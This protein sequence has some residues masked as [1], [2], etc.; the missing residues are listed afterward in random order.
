M[1]LVKFVPALVATLVLAACSSTSAEE[2]A[3]AAKA[4]EAQALEQAAARANDQA[5]NMAKSIDG[6]AAVTVEKLATESKSASYRCMNGKTLV[7]TYA[8][9]NN[10]AR[11]VNVRLGKGKNALVASLIRDDNDKDFTAFQSDKYTWKVDVGLTPKNI[12]TINGGNFSAKGANSD[13]ILAK[14]C[15]VNS[16]A[17]NRLNK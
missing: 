16:S 9:E 5:A 3:A 6:K 2:A 15:S 8:F 10:V 1:K 12:A 13:E 4:K 7:A 14:L 11:A 17:T